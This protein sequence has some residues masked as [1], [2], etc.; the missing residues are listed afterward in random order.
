MDDNKTWNVES[1]KVLHD[2]RIDHLDEKVEL[3]FKL[4]QLAVNKA[5]SKMDIRLDGFNEWR[6]QNK[7]ERSIYA[8]KQEVMSLSRLVYIGFGI[9]L[10][11]EALLKFIPQLK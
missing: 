7:D 6:Q 10:A 4:N 1:L 8:T 3:Q 5:E 11:V 2:Q 9:I